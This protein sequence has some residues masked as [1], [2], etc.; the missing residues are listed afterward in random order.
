LNKRLHILFLC[1]WYPSRVLPA[2]GD[3]IQRHAEAVASKHHVS[4]IHVVTDKTLGKNLEIKDVTENNVRTLIAYISDSNNPVVK[5]Y[6]F[7][8]AYFKLLKRVENVDL[9]HL[10]IIFPVGILALYLKWFKNIPY[11]ISEHW[12]DYQY[13][14]NKTIGSFKKFIIQLIVKN[15][16]FVCPVTK[17][18]QKAMVNYGLKGHYYSVPNVVNTHVFKP[19]DNS[20]NDF[21]ITHISNMDDKYKNI[22]ELLKAIDELQ[23]E[24]PNLK[25]M[26]I[27]SDNKR[28]N[29][30]SKNISLKNICFVNHIHHK[31][32]AS[33]LNNSDVFVLF[34]NYENLPCVILEAF[35][36]GVPVVATNVGGISEYFPKDFGFLVEPKD[37]SAFKS[38]IL[39]IY[40][41]VKKP[42]KQLMHQYAKKHFGQQA[43]ATSFSE[44]YIQSLSKS[45]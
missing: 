13:P 3:F 45:N 28:Y 34:S 42:D 36:C 12:S 21:T 11:I 17:H 2:N 8:K 23:T 24:I 14:L 5:S 18:L 25:L 40:N 27:G 39:N 43:I 9:V 38:A 41:S 7:I 22:K 20:N 33:Y 44:L 15:A 6:R 4:V 1:S 37:K 26:L 19:A 16:Q 31:K 30:L 10:N 35:A 32:I 29:E